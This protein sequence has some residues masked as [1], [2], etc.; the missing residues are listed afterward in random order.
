MRLWRRDE[1][2]LL[3]T[4]RSAMTCDQLH[5]LLGFP[6][7]KKAAER[8]TALFRAS[9]VRRTPFFQP[10]N[11]GRVPFAYYVGSCPAQQ[12]LAHMIGM[13]EVRVQVARSFNGTELCAD[14]FYAQELTVTTLRP[15]G[16]I[17]ARRGTKSALTLLELDRGTERL[18]SPKAYSLLGKLR[19]YAAYFDSEQY[20]RDF[21]WAGS[22]R[23]F[24]VAVVL[25]SPS[26]LANLQRL[27]AAEQ[28]DFVLLTTMDEIVRAGLH[29]RVWWSHDGR[30]VDL[31]GR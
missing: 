17:V 3:E 7:Y 8:M 28:F 23:G 14:F 29:A 5:R 26:R 1:L 10:S 13:A 25:L 9:H 6:S 4:G 30:I 12:I 11:R 15:D 22:F 21:S 16:A 20:Q 19:E 24:H 27:V 18:T 31:F 2:V